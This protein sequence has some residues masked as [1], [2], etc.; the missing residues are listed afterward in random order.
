MLDDK[1]NKGFP[2]IVAEIDEL[3][4]GLWNVR[5][6]PIQEANKYTVEHSVYV[7]NDFQGKG[8]GKIVLQELIVLAKNKSCI[9]WSGYWR[10]KSK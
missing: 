6:I 1:I 10:W 2:V 5:W 8:I 4:G 9:Q 3:L 7:N